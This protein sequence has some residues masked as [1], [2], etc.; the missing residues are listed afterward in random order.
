[1]MSYL[2][3]RLHPDII[4]LI[5]IEF[6]VDTNEI[7]QSSVLL[8][9]N[10][11]KKNLEILKKNKNWDK[12]KE[13]INP[14]DYLFTPIPVKN[15]CIS[16]YKPSSKSYFEIIELI[17]HFNLINSS[18]VNTLHLCND[19]TTHIDAMEHLRVTN[20]EFCHIV[21][22]DNKNIN[23]SKGK[24]IFDNLIDNEGNIMSIKN[25]AN[26]NDKYKSYFDFIHSDCNYMPEHEDNYSN[27]NNIIYIQICY[28]L[29]SQ[30]IGGNFILK[31]FDISTIFSIHIIG[32][33][34]SMYQTISITKPLSS[35]T[36]SSKKYIICKNFLQNDSNINY[37]YLKN[38]IFEN[39]S[40]NIQKLFHKNDSIINSSFIRKVIEINSIMTKSMI[41]SIHSAINIVTTDMNLSSENKS[42]KLNN[43]SR[44]NIDKCIQ[45]CINNNIEISIS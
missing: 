28:A 41:E 1:M 11:I 31:V 36:N 6:E 39:P 3:P 45:W 5:S 26:F 14:Y 4:S 9:L 10:D 8:Y 29:C 40:K 18:C 34:S 21:I 20:K 27:L 42:T 2:I 12:Y 37:H 25:F 38:K 7:G 15:Y 32:L 22:G 43:L 23:H 30:K 17:N 13:Y 16:K 35:D 24:V 33:L 44:L 19:A